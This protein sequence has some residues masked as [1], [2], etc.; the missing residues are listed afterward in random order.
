[1]ILPVGE[2]I[3]QA[4][5]HE[6]GE[7]EGNYG[8]GRDSGFSGKYQSGT[9]LKKLI[10]S[11]TPELMLPRAYLDKRLQPLPIKGLKGL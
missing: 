3:G 2:R 8:E 1:V 11:W 9:D 7:V 5:F 6:T 4:V 10:K